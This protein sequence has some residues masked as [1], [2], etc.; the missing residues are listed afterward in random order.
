MYEDEVLDRG[1]RER[2]NCKVY[3]KAKNNKT[4]GSDGLVRELLKYGGSSM[5]YLLE[6]LFGAVWQEE[7]G[8]ERGAYCIRKSQVITEVLHY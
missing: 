1:M 8:M 4:G 7:V 2:R 6:H 5:V 3:S